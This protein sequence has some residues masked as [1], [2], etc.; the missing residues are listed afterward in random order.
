[1]CGWL[2]VVVMG[3]LVCAALFA[4]LRQLQKEGTLFGNA[5]TKQVY[6]V[7]VETYTPKRYYWYVACV[8]CCAF[9]VLR[10]R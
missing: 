9:S 8:L 4:R 2:C 5:I 1:M 7:F 10:M 6:G 3:I